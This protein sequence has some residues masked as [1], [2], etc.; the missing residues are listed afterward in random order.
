M[1][2]STKKKLK[3]VMIQTRPNSSSNYDESGVEESSCLHGR[4]Y[5]TSR[6]PVIKISRPKEDTTTSS[7][8]L[9]KHKGSC[10]YHSC[11]L[12]VGSGEIVIDESDSDN[13]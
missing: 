10:I 1:F 12:L 6:C 9:G 3:T 8:I 4:T 11:N 7:T 13:Y 2:E 5:A